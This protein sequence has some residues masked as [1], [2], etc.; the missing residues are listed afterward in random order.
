MINIIIKNKKGIL[1][2]QNNFKINYLKTFKLIS[3]INSINEIIDY[4]SIMI[5]KYI[6]SVDEFFKIEW[7][8]ENNLKNNISFN[9]NKDDIIINDTFIFGIFNE[10]IFDL[11][12]IPA[13]QLF[14]VTKDFW[15]T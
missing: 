8:F 4:F 9:I 3:T 5:N 12:T 13:I 6:S 11:Y 2:Y 10:K 1:I 7:N 14:I 15:K